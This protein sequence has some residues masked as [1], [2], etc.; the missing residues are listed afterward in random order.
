MQ[1]WE[2]MDLV[3]DSSIAWLILMLVS[4]IFELAVIV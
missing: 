3:C 2:C 4:Q 1:A